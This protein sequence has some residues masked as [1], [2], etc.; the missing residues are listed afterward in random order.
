MSVTR[1]CYFNM[2]TINKTYLILS[3]MHIQLYTDKTFNISKQI[4]C[5]TA[6]KFQTPKTVYNGNH[7]IYMY[8]LFV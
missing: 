5:S 7:S 2:W 3:D 6:L 4:V 1:A 8:I